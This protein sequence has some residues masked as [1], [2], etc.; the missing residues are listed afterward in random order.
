[1]ENNRLNAVIDLPS[2]LRLAELN[3]A[4]FC[5]VLQICRSLLLLASDAQSLYQAEHERRRF[6]R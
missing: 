5:D 6:G 4:P 1:M 2:T 3:S